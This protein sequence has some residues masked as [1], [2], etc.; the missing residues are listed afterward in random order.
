[1]INAGGALLLFALLASLL[2][3]VQRTEAKKRRITF[4]F[5]LF[6][7]YIVSAYGIFRM[8]GEC[9]YTLFGRC[10]LPQYV[11]RARIVA[12]NTL[13]VALFSAILF[14][15]LFWVLIGRYNPPGSSDDIRVLGLSD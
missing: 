6:G 11:E 12:Y 3:L 5:V 1:V 10:A 8:S 9:P 2:M 15:L 13:N 7:I 4:F 14:N